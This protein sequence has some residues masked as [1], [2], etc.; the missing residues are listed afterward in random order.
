MHWC[1]MQ[2]RHSS[3]FT[4]SYTKVRLVLQRKWLI[5]NPKS[6]NPKLTRE[7][8]LINL[9]LQILLQHWHK[10]WYLSNGVCQVTSNTMRRRFRH[11]KHYSS[12]CCRTT[13]KLFSEKL[14]R[15]QIEL[16]FSF[17]SSIYVFS[18]K[19]QKPWEEYCPQN[20]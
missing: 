17:A 19:L 14:Q 18:F 13:I 9:F 5:K 16:I 10:R 11:Y 8:V 7:K 1:Y 12:K 6:S 3:E 2:M 15:L 4:K 20:R